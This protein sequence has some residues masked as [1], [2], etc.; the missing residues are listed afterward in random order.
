MFDNAEECLEWINHDPEAASNTMVYCK[1][2]YPELDLVPEKDPQR[3]SLIMMERE[4]YKMT[5][6]SEIV[7]RNWDRDFLCD[8]FAATQIC[9]DNGIKVPENA[10]VLRMRVPG[11]ELE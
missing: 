4:L 2:K 7:D 11:I 10:K 9:K 1:E 6:S 3:F 5:Y 8:R